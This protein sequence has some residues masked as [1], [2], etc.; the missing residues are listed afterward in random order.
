[1][2]K[3]ISIGSFA[4]GSYGCPGNPSD[5]YEYFAVEGDRPANGF[6]RF[7]SRHRE[8]V[9]SYARQLD[10]EKGV[11]TGGQTDYMRQIIAGIGRATVSAAGRNDRMEADRLRKLAADLAAWP[12][13]KP[14]P[15]GVE[16]YAT[17]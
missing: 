9:E 4:G 7:A 10:A 2:A 12:S 16:K 5:V 13:H 3:V 6:F 1:M 11:V 14:L 15:H 8:A 17:A